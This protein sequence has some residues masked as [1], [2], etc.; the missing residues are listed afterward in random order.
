MYPKPLQKAISCLK[1]MINSRDR[2]HNRD[3]IV[4]ITGATDGIGKHTAQKFAADSYHV[5]LHGRNEQKLQN[6]V[7]QIKDQTDNDLL[8]QVVA[9]LSSLSE[10]EELCRTL[11]DH[12]PKLDILIN[13]A[14]LGPGR[15]GDERKTNAEGFEVIFTVNYLAPFLMTH[16]LLP[17]IE[18]SHN[19]RIVNVSSSAQSPVDL[20]DLMLERKYSGSRAYSQS[21]LALIMF[22][23][24]LAEKLKERNISVNA[25]HPGSLL[26]TNMVREAFG[27]ALGKSEDG[28]EAIYYLATS[29]KLKS[30]S[31]EYFNQKAK[32]KA[33]SQAY[34]ENVRNQLWDRTIHLVG[35]KENST[36]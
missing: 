24:D 31:G 11:V 13:N 1:R 21:K 30:I 25:L 17:L 15:K 7:S 22:T 27:H 33:A 19:A 5:I 8:D 23:F 9:D 14:G 18:N 10:V 32:D 6:L 2:M 20:N 16:L 29:D 36:N 35:L 34:D 4:L 3:K 26:D 28:A 12:Y